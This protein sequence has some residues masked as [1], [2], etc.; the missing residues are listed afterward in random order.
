MS[1]NI[2]AFRNRS[3]FAL[4]SPPAASSPFNL[5]PME[6]ID[7]IFQGT[8]KL[9]PL[10]WVNRSFSFLANDL[11]RR[12]LIPFLKEG[13]Q[14][15]LATLLDEACVRFFIAKPEHA[16]LLQTAESATF[17][18]HAPHVARIA[19]LLVDFLFE[20]REL[21]TGNKP[22]SFR[23]SPENVAAAL[24]EIGSVQWSDKECREALL[25]YIP[26]RFYEQCELGL[27]A[28]SEIAHLNDLAM[29]E[30]ISA[31]LPLSIDSGDHFFFINL[32]HFLRSKEQASS[33]LSHMLTIA[34][35]RGNA[36]IVYKGL[37]YAL[38]HELS[39]E[40]LTVVIGNANR[41][42][43]PACLSCA[44]DFAP[45]HDLV[46]DKAA[47]FLCGDLQQ[48][49]EKMASAILNHPFCAR[50]PRH[51]ILNTAHAFSLNVSTILK[52][53]DKRFPSSAAAQ[54]L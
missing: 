44:L 16:A 2:A 25:D 14:E 38:P 32:L 48:K 28:Q 4:S 49:D 18:K 35:S 3:R 40:D 17:P 53:L 24:T 21:V 9:T 22:P 29:Q 47:E 39:V 1:L 27:F 46:F 51:F 52:S 33:F 45:D 30:L 31:A 5:L 50:I 54:S 11:A 12:L 34:A 36:D 26:R 23:Y 6:V 13:Q 10:T 8:E 15:G 42:N 20:Q 41:S 43:N 19:E 37:L 7:Y